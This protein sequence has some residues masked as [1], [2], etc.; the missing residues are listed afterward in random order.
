MLFYDKITPRGNLNDE[1][2]EFLL[3]TIVLSNSSVIDDK[4]KLNVSNLKENG[5]FQLALELA[6]L[7][8]A[9][10]NYWRLHPVTWWTTPFEVVPSPYLLLES[11]WYLEVTSLLSGGF[12]SIL[13]GRA[14]GVEIRNYSTQS[15]VDPP[16]LSLNVNCSHLTDHEHD[17]SKLFYAKIIN[18]SPIR[19]DVHGTIEF[20]GT[21][22]PLNYYSDNEPSLLE[23]ECTH[24]DPPH[25]Y[26]E[27]IPPEQTALLPSSNVFKF[28]LKYRD[29]H[30]QAP[31][32]SVEA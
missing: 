15:L 6:E 23:G 17:P 14:F 7:G 2:G 30:N 32:F 13:V 3:E 5:K 1:Q 22:D 31:L 19:I 16:S 25:A 29:V 26:A 8:Y 10:L 27:Y 11:G 18:P 12:E 21:F 4:K 20:W 28:S 24:C 9:K